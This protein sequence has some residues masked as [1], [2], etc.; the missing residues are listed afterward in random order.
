MGETTSLVYI[1]VT[2]L[3]V[4]HPV[5]SLRR[6][7]ELSCNAHRQR[8]RSNAQPVALCGPERGSMSPGIDL[9][10]QV[11]LLVAQ[12]GQLQ[13][14]RRRAQ[15]RPR[16]RLLVS[17]PAPGQGRRSGGCP[18]SRAGLSDPAALDGPNLRADRAAHGRESSPSGRSGPPRA[19]LDSP[20]EW[21]TPPGE[22]R[23]QP[24]PLGLPGSHPAS[25]AWSAPALLKRCRPGERLGKAARSRYRKV[26]A[27]GRGAIIAVWV[28]PQ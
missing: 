15:A 7:T 17:R 11:T 16:R 28:P 26:V 27:A 4:L 13:N 12:V 20:R 22:P 5:I 24:D 6:G 25:S 23:R 18:V 10:V 2:G 19:R 8:C 21:R 1:R 14:R 9:A 3:V